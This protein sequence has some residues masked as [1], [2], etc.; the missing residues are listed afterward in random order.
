MVGVDIW[1]G[2]GDQQISGGLYA[3]LKYLFLFEVLTTSLEEEGSVEEGLVWYTYES[4]L[5]DGSGG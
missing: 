1:V 4:W 3:P 2:V 5:Q